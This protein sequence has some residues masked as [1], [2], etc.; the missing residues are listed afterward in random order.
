MS[1]GI[2]ATRSRQPATHATPPDTTENRMLVRDASP[3]PSR[4]P[5]LGALVTCAR[6]AAETRP[7]SASGV[8]ANMILLRGTALTASA[9]PANASSTSASHREVAKPHRATARPHIVER[10]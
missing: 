9:P 4:L 3:P 10:A 1:E 8:N 5:T 6:Y 2:A 7:C